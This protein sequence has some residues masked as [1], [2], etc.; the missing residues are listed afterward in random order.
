LPWE[1]QIEP[2]VMFENEV[3]ELNIPNTARVRVSFQKLK[4]FRIIL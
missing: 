1:V 3:V 4:V 2:K